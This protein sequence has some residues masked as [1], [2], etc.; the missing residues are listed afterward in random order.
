MTYIKWDDKNSVGVRIIDEQHKH[1]V[2][3][4]NALYDSLKVKDINKISRIVEDLMSYADFHFKTEEKYFDK[5]KYEDADAH[6]AAHKKL[7]AEVQTFLNRKDDPVIVGFDLLY[8]MERWFLIHFK[9]TDIKFA[10][11]FNQNG[12]K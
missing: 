5:F 8:F 7:I 6:K 12:L 4:L 3:L 9:G 11:T 2:G 10:K 1:F